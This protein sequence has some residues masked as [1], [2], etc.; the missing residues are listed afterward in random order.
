MNPLSI[1]CDV[2]FTKHGR[3][4]KELEAGT[5]PPAPTPGRVPR[6]ARLLALAHRLERLVRTGVVKDYAEAARLGHV[7]RAR[8]SQIMSLLYL[9]PDIQEMILFLPRIERGRDWIVLHEL[10]PIAAAAD[11]T[12]Q[13]RI[14]RRLGEAFG[15]AGRNAPGGR[16]R[17]GLGGAAENPSAALP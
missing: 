8:I 16:P 2:H 12:K 3:G 11:W 10:L 14:W 1:E 5:E 4:R 17:A 13:R 7:T 15:W 9:A 6:V